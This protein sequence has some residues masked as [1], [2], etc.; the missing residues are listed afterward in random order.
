MGLGDETG[1]PFDDDQLTEAGRCATARRTAEQALIEATRAWH[2][3]ASLCEVGPERTR[4][5]AVFENVR[6]AGR[7]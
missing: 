3:Y 4:A 2:S 7:V 6:N 1:F 5:F